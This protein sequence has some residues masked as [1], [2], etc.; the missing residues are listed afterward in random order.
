M[1]KTK[2]QPP[3]VFLF[4]LLDCLKL[5]TH[6]HE[7]LWIYWR[8]KR[9]RACAVRRRPKVVCVQKAGLEIPEDGGKSRS[10]RYDMYLLQYM[11]I[12]CRPQRHLAVVENRTNM[13]SWY[14]CWFPMT[15][16][17]HSA[18]DKRWH[19]LNFSHPVS[20]NQREKWRLACL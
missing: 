12:T 11:C 1:I 16:V 9:R 14:V 3:V 17:Y 2:A 6:V 10:V 8:S 7:G 18:S 20:V 13:C 4:L 15:V 5:Y 19:F